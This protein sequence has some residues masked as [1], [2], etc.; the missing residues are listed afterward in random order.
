MRSMCL[1]L[2]PNSFARGHKRRS[3]EVYQRIKQVLRARYDGINKIP[4]LLISISKFL[5][6]MM[7]GLWRL[8]VAPIILK[9][10]L[11]FLEMR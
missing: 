8:Q 6:S 11:V 7:L 3:N 4:W 9:S 2:S 10:E 5:V 1:N